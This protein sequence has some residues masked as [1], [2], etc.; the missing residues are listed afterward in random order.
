MS[1]CQLLH[2][3]VMHLPKP[4]KVCPPHYVYRR[5]EGRSQREQQLETQVEALQ[6]KASNGYCEASRLAAGV[7]HAPLTTD[8]PMLQ[9]QLLVGCAAKQSCGRLQVRQLS[10]RLAQPAASQRGAAGSAALGAT[11]MTVAE[12]QHRLDAALAAAEEEERHLQ[13][14]QVG[15]AS[16]S[17]C[18]PSAACQGA[19]KSLSG[20]PSGHTDGA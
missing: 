2:T 5:Q 1:Q 6:A 20:R 19:V 16:G 8:R 17:V 14:M 12:L 3:F 4:L 7:R 9:T 10:A 13:G 18:S 11:G 15:H